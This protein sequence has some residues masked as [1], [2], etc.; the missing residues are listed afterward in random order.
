MTV[1][2]STKSAGL[3]LVHETQA[4]DYDHAVLYTNMKY[5][6]A[7]EPQ[8][9]PILHYQRSRAVTPCSIPL[10]PEVV[11]ILPSKRGSKVDSCA[12]TL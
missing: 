11:V 6:P 9:V 5:K 1:Q 3:A 12:G 8:S 7:H 4:N 2:L 10:I